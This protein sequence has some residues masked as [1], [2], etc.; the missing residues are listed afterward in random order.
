MIP[1]LSGNVA[2]ATA[3]G[4][5]VAN[6]CRFNDGDSAYMHKTPGSS[7]NMKTWTWNAWIKRGS[8]GASQWLME[9]YGGSGDET[10]LYLSSGNALG[11]Y[12]T[13]TGMGTN[14]TISSNNLL[15]DPSAWY[16]ITLRVDTT[17]ATADNRCRL[18]INGTE[19]SYANHDALT[20]D[21]DGAV[22]GS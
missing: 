20:Q 16:M 10:H 17:D 1:I 15:R 19:V 3:G 6:S 21:G 4:Y 9:G 18:Y 22:N 13:G 5:E 7:G 14:K 11:F 8:M 12:T 2:S